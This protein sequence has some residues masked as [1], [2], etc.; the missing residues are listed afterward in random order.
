MG[1]YASNFQPD[2]GSIVSDITD[3]TR[4]N[5]I[6]AH[7]E[8]TGLAIVEVERLWLRFK[9]LG[10]DKYGTLP[11]S[12]LNEPQLTQDPFFKNVLRS[13]RSDDG[14]IAFQTFLNA[15][16]WCEVSETEMKL[17][18][19]FQLLNNG[20]PVDQDHLVRILTRLYPEDSE[21]AVQRIAGVFMEQMDKRKKGYID[22]QTFVQWI[23]KMPRETVEPVLEFSIIPSDINAD[24]HRAFSTAQPAS[25]DE[26]QIPSDELLGHVAR[27]CH[28]RDWSLLA[29]NL[30]YLQE[31]IANIKKTIGN[32]SEKQLLEILTRWRVQNGT[33]ATTDE[34]ETALRE[35]GFGNV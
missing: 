26:P 32:D 10:C 29:N 14:D 7:A 8:A 24:A 25:L 16:Q 11:G 4:S 23:L 31:D 33:S 34:L 28:K 3:P 2:T 22:E 21:E 13:F 1:A 12:K 20:D 17:R 6:T 30:G 19:I 5:W 35:S 27:R 15:M 9:Q 18:A